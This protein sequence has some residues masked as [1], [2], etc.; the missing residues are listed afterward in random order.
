MRFLFTNNDFQHTTLRSE[1]DGFDLYVI[2]T[3]TCLTGFGSTIISRVTP[4]GL[5]RIATLKWETFGPDLVHL[6]NGGVEMTIDDFMPTKGWLSSSRLFRTPTGDWKWS[7]S[8]GD[9]ELYD[10]SSPRRRLVY[11][12]RVSQGF[13]KSPKYYLCIQ[14][15]VVEHLDH[16][17]IGFVIKDQEER[18]GRRAGNNSSMMTTLA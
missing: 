5:E 2:D 14:D 6:H 17:I 9:I 16:I 11:V 10:A 4:F 13:F 18:R 15:R 1:E 12:D 7:S 3:P 8:F